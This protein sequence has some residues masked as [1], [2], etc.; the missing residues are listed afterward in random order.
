MEGEK[1]VKTVVA[2]ALLNLSIDFMNALDLPMSA[3]LLFGTAD[4]NPA[5][6]V[7]QTTALS[8]L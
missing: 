5:E 1:G 7:N 4:R 3:G 2:W 6:A 8:R